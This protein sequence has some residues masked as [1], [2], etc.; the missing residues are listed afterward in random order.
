MYPGWPVRMRILEELA[1]DRDESIEVIMVCVPKTPVKADIPLVHGVEAARSLH[2]GLSGPFPV[3][4]V[5]L[6]M[7]ERT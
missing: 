1:E 7:Y 2:V 3:T 5:L 6:S 4:V